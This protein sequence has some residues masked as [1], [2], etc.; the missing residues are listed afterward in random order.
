[1]PSTFHLPPSTLDRMST[2][3]VTALRRGVYQDSVNLMVLSSELERLPG[4]ASAAVMMGTPANKDVFEQAGL[5]GDELRGA[6]PNDLCIALRAASDA[7]R[8]KALET[9]DAF[10]NRRASSAARTDGASA[11]RT[12][13][14][15]RRLLP[16]ANLALISVPG[17]Y[18]AREVRRALSGGLH[19]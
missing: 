19:V 18:A 13:A 10:L 1:P 9:I 2:A 12:L 7:A 11:P 6:Q 4:I 15:A 14:G 3:L 5:L 17:G 8:A 16:D